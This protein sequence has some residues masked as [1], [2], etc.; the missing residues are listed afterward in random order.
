M[1]SIIRGPHTL[2]NLNHVIS[3][4]LKH[5]VLKYEGLPY[6]TFLIVLQSSMGIKTYSMGE[7]LLK[8]RCE[9]DVLH[10]ESHTALRHSCSTWSNTCLSTDRPPPPPPTLA[11]EGVDR[12]VWLQGIR[13][14]QWCCWTAW[15][16]ERFLKLE[17]EGQLSEILI[18]IQEASQRPKRS[19]IN[20][21]FYHFLKWILF[22]MATR[23][24][25][26]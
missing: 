3:I 12:N 19:V 20:F 1:V 6:H 22:N 5:I 8:D 23:T 2:C 11:A 14:Q 4:L 10:I 15:G 18:C 17:Q 13:L 16:M 25:G 26:V 9:K 24:E 21:N 7:R